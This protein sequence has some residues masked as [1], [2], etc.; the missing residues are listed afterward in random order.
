MK[1]IKI[2]LKKTVLI[3]LSIS[4]VYIIGSIVLI[5]TSEP[6]FEPITETNSS[7]LESMGLNF[8]Q[9]YKYTERYFSTRDGIQLYS[10]FF[11]TQS[12]TTIILLH[13]ILAN[14]YQFNTSA[15]LL[16][17]TTKTN[18]VTLDLR[19][20]GRSEGKQGDI[21]YIDQ[22]VDDISDVVNTLRQ[23]NPDQNIILAGHSMG[24]GIAMRYVTKSSTEPV[25]GYLLFA[26][27]LGWESPTTRKESNPDNMK[28]SQAHVPRI[29]GTAMLNAIGIK[30]F[31]D[32]PVLFFNLQNGLP[33]VEYT[34]RSMASMSPDEASKPFTKIDKPLLVLVGENDAVFLPNEYKPL[35]EN[36]SD[37]KVHI[38]ENANHNS[39][40]YNL[41]S[42]KIIKN[43]LSE[44][45]YI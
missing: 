11:D 14:N 27:A 35:V 36:N 24:G 23:N 1:F 29:I 7:D 8:E 30:A 42:I 17:E 25:D 40:H 28:F 31:N 26:P 12:N 21:N 13:G 5:Y 18:V 4:A 3:F 43:W 22:Y 45:D 38:V 6:T 15:G 20:H 44:N 34:Y 33:I 10:N 39:V 9:N 16:N 2:N 37:G 32:K 19:G 41:Q